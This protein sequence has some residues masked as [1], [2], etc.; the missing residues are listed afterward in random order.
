MV[1]QTLMPADANETVE[2]SFIRAFRSHPGGVVVITAVSP[3][4]A[5]A[6]FT[7]TSLVSLSA[8]PPRATFNIVKSA[9]SWP[10][11]TDGALLAV[12][13][14]AESSSELAQRFAGPAAN[15]FTGDHWYSNDLGLP[16]LR[17]AIGVLVTRVSTVVPID[18]NAVVVLDI[19]QGRFS[20]NYPPLLYHNR[21]FG[22]VA[23]QP[24]DVI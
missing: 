11:V 17:D 18:L 23:V 19:Q 15:R 12:H 2:Q 1:T 7:A 6:G 20:D 16:I 4:G 24:E 8:Y 22:T 21:H 14:L 9:S 13:F 3:D 5:P 10:A